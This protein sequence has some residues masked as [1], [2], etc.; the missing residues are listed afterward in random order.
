M[1][2]SF[3]KN[4]P[5]WWSEACIILSKRDK[6]MKSLIEKYNNGKITTFKNPFYSLSKCIVGQQ[7]S[8][9]AADS[10]WLRIRNNYNVCSESC[11]LEASIKNLR[12][13]GLSERKASYLIKLSFHSPKSLSNSP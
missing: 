13:L 2:K 1:K 11:F 4:Y 3:E 5:I 6:V 9:Q 12:K 10:I 7:I 8:V